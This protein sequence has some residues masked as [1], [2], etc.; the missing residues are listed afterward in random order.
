MNKDNERLQ[1]CPL[2]PGASAKKNK[3]KVVAVI[4]VVVAITGCA[5]FYLFI[6]NFS[7]QK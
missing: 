1:K 5:V 7:K 3:E 4:T 2:I 6:F